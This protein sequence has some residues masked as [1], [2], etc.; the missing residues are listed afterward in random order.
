MTDSVTDRLEIK[1]GAGEPSLA[2]LMSAFEAFKRDN[3]ERLGEIER[4]GAAD[5]LIEE[6]LQRINQSLDRLQAERSRPQLE[7]GRVR[8]DDE[9]K[10]AFSAYV[11]RGETKALTIGS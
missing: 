3:D 8:F 6:K 1:A 5:P 9:Y 10:D 11:K 2:E 7:T 4:K